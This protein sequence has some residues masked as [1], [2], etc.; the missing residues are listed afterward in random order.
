[1]NTEKANNMKYMFQTEE[2]KAS[3]KEQNGDK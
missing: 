2:D 3:E 1:M